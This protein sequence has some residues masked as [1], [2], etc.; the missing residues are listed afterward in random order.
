M[1][2]T[3]AKSIRDVM[4]FPK[5]QSAACM[6]TGAPSSVNPKQLVELGVRV[7]KPVKA[8]GA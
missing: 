7:A 3:G 1:L 8:E 5:T 4:A 6:L 2:M